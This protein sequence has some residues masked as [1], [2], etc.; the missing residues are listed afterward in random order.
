MTTLTTP[1]AVIDYQDSGVGETALLLMPGWCQ[2]KTVFA[3]FSTL[4][5]PHFRII[6]IDWRGHGLSTTDG[7]DFAGEAL[8]EDALALV[9]HL[10]L[11]RVVPVSVAHASW[12]AVDLV[13]RLQDRAPAVVFLDW[14][15]NHP[16]PGFFASISQMQQ[17]HSWLQA[18]DALFEF[19]LAGDTSS[20]MTQHMYRDMA[21]SSFQLWRLAGQVIA[22]AY[23]QYGSPLQRLAGLKKPPKSLHI[24]SLD[25]DDEYL[26]LQQRFA[27]EHDFFKVKRLQNAKTHL[28]VLENPEE[29]LQGIR[30]VLA[31]V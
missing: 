19:W 26:A 1:H 24:Y 29:V 10:E 4:A 28:A 22:D 27:A 21:E 5:A 14:I 11:K 16:A 13:E 30:G 6:S 12:A 8:V 17:E 20:K 23:H 2:P 9:D 25:R 7:E 31:L 3:E 18:R 15:M